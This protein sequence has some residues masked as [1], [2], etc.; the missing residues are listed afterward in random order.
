MTIKENDNLA[1]VLERINLLMQSTPAVAEDAQAV[2]EMQAEDA[3]EDDIP[4]LVDVYT[5]DFAQLSSHK[6][7]QTKVNALLK[8]VRPFIQMEVKKVV[9]QESV[10]LEKKL[11]KHLEA[12]LIETLRKRL[13]SQL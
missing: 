11:A 7:R 1:A 6:E 3:A 9:L 8:E 5:G 4:E 10:I 13:M 12:D 2:D